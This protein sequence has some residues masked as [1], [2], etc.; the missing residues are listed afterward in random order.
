MICSEHYTIFPNLNRS[1][2]KANLCAIPDIILFHYKENK[3]YGGCYDV[4][5][6]GMVF[7][8]KVMEIH[9]KTGML[10]QKDLISIPFY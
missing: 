6:D 7:M 3:I 4:K 9:S 8:E 5:A 10:F 1:R 2:A